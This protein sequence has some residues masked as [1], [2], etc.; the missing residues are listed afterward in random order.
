MFACAHPAI[1]R[2]IRGPLILQAILGFDAALIAGC[3]LVSPATMGQRLARA[4]A[5]IKQAGIAFRLPDRAGMPQR[6]DAVL[7]AIYATF[8]EGWSDPAGVR[9]RERELT[10]ERSG[11][12]DWW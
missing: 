10:E 6:L 5:E 4:K 9:R 7:E 11:S 8:T 12:A 3:Y 2:Q 1:D